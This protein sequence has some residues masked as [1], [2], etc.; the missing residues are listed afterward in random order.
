MSFF[1]HGFEA[2]SSP[3][4]YTTLSFPNGVRDMVEKFAKWLFGLV[5]GA[6]ILI[7]GLPL[8]GINPDTKRFYSDEAADD[9]KE[10]ARVK[11]RTCAANPD[12]PECS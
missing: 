10:R 8:L 3:L 2:V 11:A 6:M 1:S 5:L 9:A 7:Y 12:W 4:W